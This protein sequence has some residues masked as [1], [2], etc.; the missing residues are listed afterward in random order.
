LI[1][2]LLLSGLIVK[3]ENLHP[4]LSSKSEVPFAGKIMTSYWAYEALAVNQFTNNAYEKYFYNVDKHASFAT[5][6]LNF[7]LDAMRTKLDDAEAL[8]NE[9]NNDAT[10][11]DALLTLKNELEDEARLSEIRFLHI[12]LLSTNSFDKKTVIAMRKHFDALE[13]FYRDKNLQASKEK[14]RIVKQLAPNQASEKAFAVWK[15]NNENLAVADAVKNVAHEDRI[16]EI[17]NHF[18][19]LSDN[20]FN[21]PPQ[22]NF[23]IAHFYAPE[24][25]IFG[26][27][28]ETFNINVFVIWVMSF[29]LAITLYFNAFANAFKAMGN[30]TGWRYSKKPKKYL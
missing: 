10:L 24:K 12:N 16:E 13:I 4:S 9:K 11:A 14:Q 23:L 28:F 7:W 21:L 27:F 18:V 29:V 8:L 19:Q 25:P 26:S 3:F 2:Q 20:I 22:S 5:F 6:K 17:D 1:P 30:I 15:Q